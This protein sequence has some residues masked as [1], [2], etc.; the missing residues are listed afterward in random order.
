MITTDDGGLLSGRGGGDFGLGRL[1]SRGGGDLGLGRLNSRGGGDV[2]RGSNLGLDRR[3]TGGLDMTID[4][5]SAGGLGLA[6]GLPGSAGG[7]VEAV[8]KLASR[9]GNGTGLPRSRR[10]IQLHRKVGVI[11]V[12]D[13]KN[14]VGR[15]DDEGIEGIEV[16]GLEAR[17]STGFH[18]LVSRSMFASDEAVPVLVVVVRGSS[19]SELGD[20]RDC[21]DNEGG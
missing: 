9:G 17:G 19:L 2:S 8:A 13:R 5:G 7:R 18:R 15:E 6:H 1:N 10:E 12:R 11:D 16:D 4:R 3:S 21:S 14:L 20:S